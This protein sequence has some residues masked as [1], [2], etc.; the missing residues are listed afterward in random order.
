MNIFQ[1]TVDH[2]CHKLFPYI[3]SAFLLI[4]SLGLTSWQTYVIIALMIFVQRYNYKIGYFS[5][6]VDQGVNLTNEEIN[7]SKSEVED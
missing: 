3:I 4:T 5:C 2:L 1:A 7:E 6:I